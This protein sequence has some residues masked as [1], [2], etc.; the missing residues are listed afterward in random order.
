MGNMY[1]R[2]FAEHADPD[3]EFRGFPGEQ[4]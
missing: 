2:E 4:R 3:G 1:C